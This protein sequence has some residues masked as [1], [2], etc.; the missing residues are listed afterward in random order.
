MKKAYLLSISILIFLTISGCTSDNKE[1]AS[2][3][4]ER[5]VSQQQ[6]VTPTHIDKDNP[7]VYSF[8]VRVAERRDLTVVLNTKTP[9]EPFFSVS[10]IS[11]YDGEKLLQTLEVPSAPPTD[12]YA[13]DGLFV[14]EDDAVGTPDVR[15]VNFDGIADFGLLTVNAYPKNLPYSY[16]LWNNDKQHFEYGFTLFG[17]SALEVDEDKHHLIETSHDATGGCRA[18][19]GYLSDG[20]LYKVAKK[21]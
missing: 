7:D 12:D 11:V 1:A 19:Y 18:V 20:T 9:K 8:T 10:S 6:Q 16:Y 15:D 3:G 13:W 5:K 14:N 17:A 21:E 4:D 2:A